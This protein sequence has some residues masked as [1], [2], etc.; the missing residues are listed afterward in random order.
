MLVDNNRATEQ[1][2]RMRK[3]F[4]DRTGLKDVLLRTHM[5]KIDVML[6]KGSCCL[7]GRP[8]DFVCLECQYKGEVEG[9]KNELTR[10]NVK[11]KYETKL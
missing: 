2:K 6:E 3:W 9:I 5:N 1:N 8:G 7:C 10:R 11:E 4:K